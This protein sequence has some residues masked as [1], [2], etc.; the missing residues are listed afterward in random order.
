MVSELPHINSNSAL[1]SE[2]VI[3]EL[4]HSFSGGRVQD[5][6]IVEVMSGIDLQILCPA[7]IS[8]NYLPVE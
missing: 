6:C 5:Q 3:T 2:N 8:S 4:A 1:G 7:F